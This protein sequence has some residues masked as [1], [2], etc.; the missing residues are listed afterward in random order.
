MRLRIT[1]YIDLPEITD[2][3]EWGKDTYAPMGD[4]FYHDPRSRVLRRYQ[5]LIKN[6]TLDAL[7]TWLTIEP[8]EQ[9]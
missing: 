1:T 8:D 6:A 4:P 3:D 5:E 9:A 7:R 2:L